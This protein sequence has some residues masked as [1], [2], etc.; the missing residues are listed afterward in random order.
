MLSQQRCFPESWAASGDCGVVQCQGNPG[1][2]V[3]QDLGCNTGQH[4]C[5]ELLILTPLRWDLRD[6]L[7]FL[8]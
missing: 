2:S 4:P 8:R 7:V 6:A 1:L 5:L 3:D